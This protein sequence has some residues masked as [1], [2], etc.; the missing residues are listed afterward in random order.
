MGVLYL[1]RQ[2]RGVYMSNETKPTTGPK[3]KKLTNVKLNKDALERIR[4]SGSD[5]KPRT[6][7]AYER[8]QE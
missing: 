5:E 2:K 6:M 1:D 7:N 3:V 4:K 8:D